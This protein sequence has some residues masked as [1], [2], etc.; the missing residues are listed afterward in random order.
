MNV[1]S[2]QKEAET[3]FKSS[4]LRLNTQPL[5]A[6]S[7]TDRQTC[8]CSISSGSKARYDVTVLYAS[9]GDTDNANCN[10]EWMA[11]SKPDGMIV[12]HSFS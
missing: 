6:R 12:V 8:Q 11:V 7:Q 10:G 3:A 4:V 5:G 9:V 1:C 2:D